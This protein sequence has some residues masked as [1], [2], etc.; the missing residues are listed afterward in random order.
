MYSQTE[1][2]ESK[3][4]LPDPA[5]IMLT[6]DPMVVEL[7]DWLTPV[8]GDIEFQDIDDLPEPVETR[9]KES[10]EL[11]FGGGFTLDDVPYKKWSD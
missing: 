7:D 8:E 11:L 10:N 6:A 9:M 1:T 3:E 5:R 2:D 4:D